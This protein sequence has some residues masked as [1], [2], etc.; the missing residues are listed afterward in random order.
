MNILN[1]IT[2]ILVSSVFF[3]A[4]FKFLKQ[5]IFLAHIVVGLF[6][7]TYLFGNFELTSNNQYFEII[8]SLLLFISGLTVNIK[9]LKD[10]GQNTIIKNVLSF[11]LISIFFYFGLSFLGFDI[12]ESLII[13][14]CLSLSSSVILSK[15]ASDDYLHRNLFNKIAQ[16]H[17]LVQSVFLVFILVFLNSFS[18]VL[19]IAIYSCAI[20]LSISVFATLYKRLA[21]SNALYNLLL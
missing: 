5:P 15:V 1:Q 7:G 14:L 17:L 8:A 9:H 13:S 3:G 12:L 6:V 10:L 16:S 20:S 18:F 19:I 4:I 11:L 21:L 2:I